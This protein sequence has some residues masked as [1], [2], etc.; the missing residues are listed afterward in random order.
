MAEHILNKLGEDLQTQVII[1]PLVAVEPGDSDAAHGVKDMPFRGIVCQ[2]SAVVLQVGKLQFIQATAKA[3]AHLAADLAESGPVH[4][5]M[6]QGPLQK[7]Y[8][9]VIFHSLRCALL[10]IIILI[11]RQKPFHA[12]EQYVNRRQLYIWRQ[13]NNG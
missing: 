2:V 12:A 5:Q 7:T 3:L 1:N 9:V 10:R 8:A 6:G 4:M 11:N 13:P